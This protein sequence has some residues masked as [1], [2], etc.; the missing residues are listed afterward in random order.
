MKLA[1]VIGNVVCSQKVD[2]WEGVKLLLVQP[3]NER[4]E[5]IGDP[6]I[7][8]DTVQAGPDDIVFYEGGREAAL[9]LKNWF[10]PSDATIMGIVDRV[11]IEE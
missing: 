9:G 4:L 6:L 5:E 8:C 11:D 2:S 3:L 10:N 1:R 7:A